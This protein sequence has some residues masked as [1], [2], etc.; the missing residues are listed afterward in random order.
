[1]N[2]SKIDD[3][4]T[5]T[6]HDGAVIREFL[7]PKASG[8]DSLSIAH[9]TIPPRTKVKPH[10]HRKTEE[11]YHLISGAGLMT[12]DGQEQMIGEGEAVAILRGQWH[13]IENQSSEPLVM[14]VTCAPPWVPEDQF[15]E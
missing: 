3:C 15:F 8:L 1:M 4:P 9:I 2:I 7:G 6:D 13:S 11:T 5:F 14:L 12:L 10:F